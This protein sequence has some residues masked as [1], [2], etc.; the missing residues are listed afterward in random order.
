MGEPAASPSQLHALLN[1]LSHQE[2]YEEIEQFKQPEAIQEYGP[3]F[4]NGPDRST[5]TS[6]SLQSLLTKLLMPLPGLKAVAPS[7]WPDRIQPFITALSAANLSESYD[8]G[9]I[10]QRRTV[11]TGISTLLEY[12]N[13]GYFGGCTPDSS[14]FR[15]DRAYDDSSHDDAVAAF[16][17]LICSVVYGNAVDELFAKAAETDR[18]SEQIS[19]VRAAHK[20]IVLKYAFYPRLIRIHYRAFFVCLS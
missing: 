19:L 20:F 1:V 4:Q 6:P 2:L 14:S 15:Q 18:L 7:F 11:S 16:Q 8:K 12:P 9:V 13:R 5:S 17:D 10:G 3:P